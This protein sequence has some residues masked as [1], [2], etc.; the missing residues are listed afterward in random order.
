ME[1]LEKKEKYEDLAID[2]NIPKPLQ[3]AIRRGSVSADIIEHS[4]DADEA[5]KA[6]MGHE[7]ETLLL[8]DA[9]NK[10]LLRRIDLN[11][12]P[13]SNAHTTEKHC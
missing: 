13:A 11:L 5:M 12:M 4:H 1:D 6:F 10:R 7:G 3:D 9:T 2:S 8:D